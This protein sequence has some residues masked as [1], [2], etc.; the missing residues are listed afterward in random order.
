MVITLMIPSPTAFA[1]VASVAAEDVDRAVL[2]VPVNRMPSGASVAAS[3][4]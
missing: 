1:I 2:H 3:V 4:C